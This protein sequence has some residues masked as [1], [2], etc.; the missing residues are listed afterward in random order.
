MSLKE[1]ARHSAAREL[2]SRHPYATLF[3][4]PVLVVAAAA[5]VIFGLVKL[6]K[7]WDGVHV[8]APE[9]PDLNLGPMP[10]GTWVLVLAVA[11]A[12]LYVVIRAIYRALTYGSWR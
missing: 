6:I 5:V 2:G 9:V 3:G 7:S 12:V 10:A 11:A 8:N 4:G 1:T